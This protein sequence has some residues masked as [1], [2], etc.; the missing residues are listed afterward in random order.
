L[1][2]VGA[3]V[4]SAILFLYQMPTACAVGTSASSAVLMDGESGR[5]LYEHNCH[6]PRLIAS[7]TKLMTALV[8]LESG[9]DLQQVVTVPDQAVGV[10]GSSI[11]L[12]YGEELTF[13]TL[14]YGMLLKSGND[15]AVAVAIIC[16]GSVEEFANEMNRKATELGMADSHFENPN[17]L[18]AQTHYS[19]AYDMALLAKACLDNEQLAK[20]VSTKNAV[21]GQRSFSNHN[22]LLWQYEGCVGLKTGYT[23][24]AGRTLV[25]AARKNGATL[26]AVTLNDPNDWKDHGELLDWGFER[27]ASVS[28]AQKG[29][30]MARIPVE[31]GLIPF[32]DA[33]AGE[34]LN[35]PLSVEDSLRVETQLWSS[36][37]Q[38]PVEAGQVLGVLRVWC[39]DEIA[40]EI[41]LL[42]AENVY[43]DRVEENGWFRSILH[44]IL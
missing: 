2:R 22:K 42:A 34:S 43:S 14:L 15:A 38:A 32:A 40:S 23:Q 21:F 12:Q 4:L 1:K 6:E 44:G 13:E 9:I 18:N 30:V 35:Y 5:V 16:S 27:Y 29:A 28:V 24:K 33:A 37:M 10:E 17:G 36:C 19:S 8:A 26:I 20:I 25:S 41:P 31:G 39:N 11:Y 7:I 3:I